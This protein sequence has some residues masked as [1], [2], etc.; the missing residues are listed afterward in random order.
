MV[1]KEKGGGRAISVPWHAEYIAYTS[2]RYPRYG[3]REDTEG[4]P[5]WRQGRCINTFANPTGP[6]ISCST[7][8]FFFDV[9][10]LV[11]YFLG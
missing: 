7:P 1:G 8:N 3:G 6:T 4:A 11:P 9:S 10:V 5:T 2:Q